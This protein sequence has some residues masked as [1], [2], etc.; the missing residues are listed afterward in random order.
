MEEFIVKV[1]GREDI[2]YV[3]EILKTIDFRL[4]YPGAARPYLREDLGGYTVPK[5]APMDID[6]HPS[7]EMLRMYGLKSYEPIF[8]QPAN[9]T[10]FAP[11][12]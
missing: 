7:E 2:H 1:A 12:D 11:E 3:E 8:A 10:D 4:V 9:G 6:L 5:F